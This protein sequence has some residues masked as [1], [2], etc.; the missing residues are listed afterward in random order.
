M[1]WREGQ[2]EKEY[3][4]NIRKLAYLEL[5]SLSFIKHF[6]FSEYA[7]NFSKYSL[8]PSRATLPTTIIKIIKQ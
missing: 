2:E 6:L 8:F 1:T 4:L 5:V 7:L 3:F